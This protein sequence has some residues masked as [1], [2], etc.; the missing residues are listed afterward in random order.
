V[1]NEYWRDLYKSAPVGAKRW[2]EGEFAASESEE[3]PPDGPDPDIPMII[4]KG[5]VRRAKLG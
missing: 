3:E 5:Q 4:Q 1:E 2:L